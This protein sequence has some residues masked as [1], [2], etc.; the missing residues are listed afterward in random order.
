MSARHA[1][2]FEQLGSILRRKLLHFLDECL[3]SC[4]AEL[5]RRCNARCN[6]RAYFRKE[7]FLPSRRA[8]AKHSSRG[9]RGI[10]KL[11]R[12]IG[13]NVNCVAGLH[14]AFLSAKRGLD[15]AFNDDKGFLEIMPVWRRSAARRNVH[16]DQAI[17]AVGIIGR[18][19]NGI[20]V[21]DQTNVW[22]IRTSLISQP[23]RFVDSFSSSDNAFIS[24]SN[25][26]GS[27][28][29]ISRICR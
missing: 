15:F 17:T 19:Q 18:E 23:S 10:V 25:V 16:V 22:Q 21:S 3:L 28:R 6:R 13:W 9:G 11:M 2:T 8:D 4:F 29:N 26:G 27:S 5:W 20:S 24:R 14:H 7:F 1:L 12:R